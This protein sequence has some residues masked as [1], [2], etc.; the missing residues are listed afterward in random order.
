M[1]THLEMSQRGPSRWPDPDDYQAAIRAAAQNPRTTSLASGLSFAEDEFLGL[2]MISG[3]AGFVFHA[4][5]GDRHHAFKVFNKQ[6]PQ[7]ERRYALIHDHLERVPSRIF[8]DFRYADEA[9]F[10][11][12]PDG[13]AWFPAVRMEWC[14]GETLNDALESALTA[15]YQPAKWIRAWLGV[16]EEL[17]RTRTAHGDL[18]PGNVIVGPDGTMRLIDYDG[19]YVPEM[20]SEL[21][22]AESGHPAY[23]HPARATDPGWFGSHLDGISALVILTTLAGATQAL[24]AE[25]DDEGL[26]LGSDDL[27]APSSSVMFERLSRSPDPTPELVRLLRDALAC[28]LGPCSQIDE[29]ARVCGVELTPMDPSA[30]DAAPVPEAVSQVDDFGFTISSGYDLPRWTPVPTVAQTGTAPRRGKAA[31]GNATA[32]TPRPRKVPKQP[33]KAAA[34]K[35]AQAAD[36]AAK[37]HVAKAQAAYDRA[38]EDDPALVAA[39]VG[40]GEVRLRRGDRQGAFEDLDQALQLD[41]GS[42]D[43]LLARAAARRL[44]GKLKASLADCDKAIAASPKVAAAFVE[45]GWTCL[46]FSSGRRQDARSAFVRAAAL[47]RQSAAAYA[48]RGVAL[49]LRGQRSE[50]KLALDRALTL[51][52]KQRE[53]LAGRAALAALEGGPPKVTALQKAIRASR[54]QP[55]LRHL[56]SYVT[57]PRGRAAS[58]TST[59][60]VTKQPVMDLLRLRL[61]GGLL[62]TSDTQF[63]RSSWKAPAGLAATVDAAPFLSRAHKRELGRRVRSGIHPFERLLWLARWVSWP[64]VEPSEALLVTT[65]RLIWTS[66][67]P[68]LPWMHRASESSWTDVVSAK[69]EPLQ[70]VVITLAG[71]EGALG[72]ST[73]ADAV[74]LD[75]SMDVHSR[76]ALAFALGLRAA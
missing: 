57:S 6:A 34:A 19:M 5:D 14:A 47:D 49:V 52:P 24:W 10:V 74:T 12:T 1:T 11:K 63:T 46:S 16:I 15:G 33:K 71:G 68:L 58:A 30:I 37:Y 7:R 31:R 26:L 4:S 22:A 48:G 17:R 8:A 38:I 72:I 40:R 67:M 32:T 76:A 39:Y 25:R 61:A 21:E 54:E 73:V 66:R 27:A 23:Q 69:F 28:S 53:A 29:A 60:P 41:P 59:A 35:L 55:A 44:D 13:T 9:L 56:L 43:A 75:P 70:G 62:P 3:G 20:R 18:H 42:V 51:D 2:E 45:R 50:A 64:E 65:D 36:L